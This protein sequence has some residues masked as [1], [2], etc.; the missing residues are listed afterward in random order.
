MVNTGSFDRPS[1][2]APSRQ[3]RPTGQS[4]TPTATLTQGSGLRRNRLGVFGV[5][6]FVIAAVAPMAAIVGGSPVV[7]ATVGPGTPAV[8][9]LA[10]L[11]FAVFSVG[12]VTMSRHI[13]NAGGFV[14]YI[15]RGLGARAGTAAAGVTVLCYVS[16]L[17]GLL[18]Q[19]GVFAEQLLSVRLGLNIP[20]EIILLLSIILVTALTARGVDMSLRVLGVL[21]T[22]EVLTFVVLDLAI[23]GDGGGTSGASLAGFDPGNVFNAGLGVAFLFAFACF[24]GFEATVVFSEE[25]KT[26]RRTI[27]RAAYLSIAFIGIFYAFTTWCL[28]NAAG[29]DAVQQQAGDKLATGTFVPDLAGE[30]VGGW[31]VTLLDVLVVTSFLAMLI[32]FANMFARYLF[33]LGRAGVLP[34]SLGRTTARNGTPAVAAIAIGVMEIVVLTGFELAGADPIGITFFWLLAL[35]TV[36]LIAVLVLTCVAMLA[37]FSRTE[38]EEGAWQTKVAPAI[39]LIGFATVLYLAIANYDILGGTG[40]GKWLLLGIPVCA[41]AGWARAT[42]KRSVDFS[43]DLSSGTP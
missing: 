27:P 40:A 34:A 4:P 30:Y 38:V 21:V 25:A 10:A 6:F 24:T 20:R 36:A 1:Q 9:L 43:T 19:Y 15:A 26:P 12:Y 29:L 31:F 11:L 41:A 7:F 17:C 42:V 37:F 39:A 22:I 2:P 3:D 18:S 35:G 28:S 16:L 23:L 32:G 5:A 14:A 8:F 13:T 33:A